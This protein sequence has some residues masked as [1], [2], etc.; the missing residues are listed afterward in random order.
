MI[1]KD[2]RVSGVALLTVIV[3]LIIIASLAVTAIFIMSGSYRLSTH[4]VERIKAYYVAEAGIVHNLD[5]LRQ[6]QGVQ[7]LLITLDGKEYTAEITDPPPTANVGA[8]GQYEV[9]V[10]ESKVKYYED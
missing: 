6:G 7:D 8:T 3:F 9:Q 2:S 4:Q 5:R 1:K 10:L